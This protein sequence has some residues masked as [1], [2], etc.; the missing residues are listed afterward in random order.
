MIRSEPE[1]KG[2]IGRTITESEPWWPDAPSPPSSAPNV[3]MIV[4]DDTGFA[5]LGCYIWVIVAM[6]QKEQ[7]AV[8]ISSL[9]S[10]PCLI[11][12][13]IAYVWGWIHVREW[14]IACVIIVWTAI[15]IIQ[16]CSGLLSEPEW[17]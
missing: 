8:A 4:L 7:T 12:L 5:H 1:F 13:F 9:V 3:V 17:F 6:F 14:K 11:G 16:A 2:R 10:L 15:L